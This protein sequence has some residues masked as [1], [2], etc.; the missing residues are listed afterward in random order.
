MSDDSRTPDDDLEAT[1]SV[2]DPELS[3]RRAEALGVPAE[4]DG[5]R[6]LR[7][8]GEGGMGVVYEAEQREPRRRVAFKVLREGSRMDDLHVRL[9]RREVETLARLRHPNIA[10]IYGSGRLPDGRPYFAMELIE[11]DTLAAYLQ[12]RPSPSSRVELAHRLAIARRV[13]DAVHYAHQRGVI[14]RD[15]KPSNIFVVRGHDSGATGSGAAHGPDVKILDFGLARLTDD[16]SNA[17]L[18]SELGDIRGTLPYMSPEQAR[19]ESRN[20][21]VRSDVYALGVILYELVTGQRPYD[22]QKAALLEAVRVICET[23]PRPM[24]DTP[25]GIGRVDADLQTI[26]MKA[27]EKDAERRYASAAAFGDDLERYLTSQ[28]ILAH[29]PSAAYQLRMLVTRHRA[30]VA[31]AAVALAVIVVA[32]VV[33][34]AMFFRARTEAAKARQVSAFLSEMLSGV[35][36]SVALGRDTALLR[37]VLEATGK[38]VSTELADQPD[39][40]AGIEQV[41]GT[42]WLQL[43]DI[44]QAR[45]YANDAYDKRRKLHRGANAD[46]AGDLGLLTNVAWRQGEFAAA[47]SLGRVTLDMRRKLGKGPNA[48]TAG[49]LTDLGSILL[50]V[51]RFD[52]AEPMLR[53]ALTMRQAIVKG[54]DRDLAV[55]WNA[56]GNVMQYRGRFETA[57][58]LYQLALAMHVRVLGELHPDVVVDLINLGQLQTNRSRF[59]A[60]D[61]MLRHAITLG[62]KLYGKEHPTLEVAWSGLSDALRRSGDFA[63]AERADQT[64]IGMAKRLHGEESVAYANA[65]QGLSVT[66]SEWKGREAGLPATLQ[67]IAILRRVLASDDVQLSSGLANLADTYAGLHRFAAADSL[68]REVLATRKKRMGEDSPQYLLA[69]NN[70][71][72]MKLEAGEFAASERLFRA[73]YEGRRRTQGEAHDGTIVSMSDLASLLATCGRF[74]EAESLWARAGVLADSVVG[75]GQMLSTVIH[76]LHAHALCEL[77]REREAAPEVVPALEGVTKFY[78]P[79]NSATLRV[80]VTLARTRAAQGRAPEADSLFRVALAAPDADESLKRVRHLEYGRFLTA[81]RRYPEAARELLVVEKLTREGPAARIVKRLRTLDALVAL[82]EAWGR[83]ADA[84]HWRATRDREKPRLQALLSR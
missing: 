48:E 80:A 51:G 20:L 30:V 60:A 82:Y 65:L 81:Q 10:A 15:L 19:G 68:Y 8:L 43:G 41:L 78:G 3:A 39:V 28:P 50:Q 64:A 17:T 21:D 22:L 7:V 79:A 24:R 55:Q 4:V 58:S 59:T 34:T 74:G 29:A 83:P 56:L 27:L 12:G 13:A 9:F 53:E 71:A 76:A 33:S 62:E 72:R 52:D 66:L 26:V 2:F 35:G 42:T 40:A 16:D 23:P 37:E 25:S 70:Y 6:M 46:L 18:T 47:E 44:E 32:S 77:G 1:R 73:T 49:A 11:G 67:S 36:P 31:A 57:D 5:Y 69:L 38:R 84:A 61:S 54:D 45:K 14:H 75:R 63:G